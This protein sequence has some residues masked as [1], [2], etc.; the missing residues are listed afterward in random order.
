M[1]KLFLYLFLNLTEVKSQIYFKFT[2]IILFL[3]KLK[4]LL[5]KI[6][7]NSYNINKTKNK[8]FDKYIYKI[9]NFLK[10]HPL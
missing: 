6:Y 8:Q 4:L 9:K 10:T 5:F 1:I 3:K 7:I 2:S